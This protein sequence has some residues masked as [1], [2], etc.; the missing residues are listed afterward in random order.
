M[1]IFEVEKREILQRH[2]LIINKMFIDM[3][4]VTKSNPTFKKGGVKKYLTLSLLII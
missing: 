1:I 2:S 4:E 3:G